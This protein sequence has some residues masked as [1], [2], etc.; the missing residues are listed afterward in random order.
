MKSDKVK[1]NINAWEMI[2]S[3]KKEKYKAILE[4]HE[5]LNQEN[6]KHKFIDFNKNRQLGGYQIIVSKD[7][8]ELMLF[9]QNRIS[10]GIDNNLIEAWDYK[11]DPIALTCDQALFFIKN[12]KPN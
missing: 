9:V 5:K 6:I 2:E 12:I 3:V 8:I 4:L 11:E 7:N 1:S 10:R